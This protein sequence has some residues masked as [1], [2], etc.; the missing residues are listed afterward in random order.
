MR[1][2]DLVRGGATPLVAFLALVLAP[3]LAAQETGA[4][5]GRVIAGD[6][7]RPLDGVQVFVAGTQIGGL[8]GEDGSFRLT[9]VPAGEHTVQARLLG[10]ATAERTVTVEAGQTTTLT[11]ELR[12]RAIALDEIVVT[13]TGTG[14]VERKKLGNTIA[15]INTAKLENAPT[16]NVSEVLSAREPG[17]QVLPASGLA[18]EGSQIRIRGSSSLAQSNEPIVYVDGVRMNTGGD[19]GGAVDAGGGGAGSSSRLDD[20]NPSSI[21]RIEILKGAAA[22]TLY[23]TEAS[24]GVI[25]IFTKSGREGPARWTMEFTGGIEAFPF[26][27]VDL[28]SD[29]PRD[30]GQA[31][32]MNEFLGCNVQ[33]FEVCDRPIMEEFAETGHYED[34]RGSVNGGS[35]LMTYFLSGRFQNQDGPFGL[36]RFGPAED[37]HQQLAATANLN[38]FPSDVLR[39]QFRSNYTSTDH[40]TPQTTNNIFGAWPSGLMAQLRLVTET[41]EFGA[42]AFATTEEIMQITTEQEVDHFGGSIGLNFQPGE[43]VSLDGTFGIDYSGSRAEEQAPFGWNVDGVTTSN[44]DGYRDINDQ[45]VTQATVELRG[46]WDAEFASDWSSTLTVGAQG[47]LL[48]QVNR[49]GEG[50]VFPGPGLEVAAA[51]ANQTITEDW[52]Q[53]ATVG[54]FA[55]EQIGWRDFAFLTVGARYDANSAFGEE[56]SGVLYPKASFS[57]IPSDMDGWGST[58]LSTFRIRGAI[59]QSGLQPGAF[60][61]FRTFEALASAEGAGVAPDNLG[62]Q[63]L[64][65][66]VSTEWEFGAE[67]GLLDDRYAV[68]AT[69]WDRTVKDAL[70]N[71]QFPVTGGFQ[72]L[73]LVNIGELKGRGLDLGLNGTVYSGDDLSVDLYVNGAFLSEEVTDLGGSPPIKAGGSYPRYRNFIREGFTPGAFFGA[74]LAD[75][76]IPLNLEGACAAPTEA[77]ALAY[78]S[79]PRSPDDFEVLI[80]DAQGNPSSVGCPG[81][82]FLDHHL[83]KPFPDWQGSLG[84]DIAFLDGFELQTNFEYKAGDFFWSDLSGAFAQSNAFIGRNTPKSARAVATMMDP[85]STAQERF[86]AAMVWA[87]ELRALSPMS[88]LNLIH[89][90]DYLRWRELSL[91]YNAPQSFADVFGFSGLSFSLRARNL[92]LWVNDE[93]TGISPELAANARCSLDDPNAAGNPATDCNFLQGTEAFREPLAKRW[94]LGVRANF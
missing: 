19:F 29:F 85:A 83:G 69:Y 80:Q 32:R 67:F 51:A 58:T 21:E 28:L 45:T 44:P 91:T 23:G 63:D 81:G 90:A 70:V 15:S 10:Y 84:A 43:N 27:R 41:N 11:F 53:N 71:K 92:A 2:R 74:T 17:V 5:A 57:V 82:V 60:D 34:L 88:G 25:Q 16:A 42:P 6:T 56:F 49:G 13:G 31:D 3:P 78:F 79:Q 35:N 66:E 14:G 50:E 55:Q 1:L 54:V 9:E 64:K 68:S 89:P 59:G 65:P 22:A 39:V 37:T 93:Y 7:Q 47:F 8:T 18:G 33:L 61:K 24:N 62:N 52:L 26:G 30:Q 4:V 48:E 77:Q 20:I 12:E 36:E 87:T 46:G 86:D 94:L 76:P 40:S 75:V 72:D 38:I 73:Q